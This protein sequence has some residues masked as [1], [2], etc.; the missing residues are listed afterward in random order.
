[1]ARSREMIARSAAVT[2]GI[3]SVSGAPVCWT[4]QGVNVHRVVCR[5]PSSLG[6]VT[7]GWARMSTGASPRVSAR[8]T[9]GR[10]R[11]WSRDLQR[12]ELVFV[13]QRRENVVNVQPEHL[14][15]IPGVFADLVLLTQDLRTH[16]A[17]RGRARRDTGFQPHR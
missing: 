6:N 1:M 13:A 11:A 2:F 3:H 4:G 17:H 7:S 16:A 9:S 15:N 5:L 8:H 10:Q 14:G 12:P